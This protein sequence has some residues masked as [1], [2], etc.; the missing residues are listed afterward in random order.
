MKTFRQIGMR[1][2]RMSRIYMRTCKLLFNHL[3]QKQMLDKMFMDTK[4]VSQEMPQG[5]DEEQQEEDRSLAAGHPAACR[6]TPANGLQPAP[7]IAPNQGSQGRPKR[8]K[9][10]LNKF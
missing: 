3:F 8:Q 6:R 5:G 4:R 10:P 2:M 7:A 1:K 9:N